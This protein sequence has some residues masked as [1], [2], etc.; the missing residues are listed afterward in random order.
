VTGLPDIERLQ[1]LALQPGD[2]LVATVPTGITA[3]AVLRT[4]GG[5]VMWCYLHGH[6]W[7]RVFATSPTTSAPC[8]VRVCFVCQAR[9][10]IR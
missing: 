9:E 5:P 10:E 3:E 6:D 4:G 8:L 7:S 1:V 2:V